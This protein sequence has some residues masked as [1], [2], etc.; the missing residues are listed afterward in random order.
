MKRAG[1]ISILVLVVLSVL[2]FGCCAG[3]E[4]NT[5]TIRMDKREYTP[6]ETLQV[7]ITQPEGAVSYDISVWIK[8]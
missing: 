1:W 7:T 8:V 6:G 4:G 3:A 2:A 5:L